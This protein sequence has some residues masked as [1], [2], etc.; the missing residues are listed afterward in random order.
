MTSIV[1]HHID[2]HCV[3]S[4]FITLVHSNAEDEKW[5][6]LIKPFCSYHANIYQPYFKHDNVEVQ[7]ALL[8]CLAKTHKIIIFFLSFS[9]MGTKTCPYDIP[10]YYVSKLNLY[11]WPRPICMFIPLPSGESNVDLR[12]WLETM[13]PNR[14]NI[15]SLL[16]NEY[17]CTHRFFWQDRLHS[18][19][20]I[21]G[22]IIIWCTI[23][24]TL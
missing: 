9:S 23:H 7:A 22:S 21:V 12:P 15:T 6:Y 5:D 24:L 1:Y 16:Y 11:A 20:I 8:H 2:I 17:E 13:N 18:L 14:I 19:W 4:S 10:M 3:S